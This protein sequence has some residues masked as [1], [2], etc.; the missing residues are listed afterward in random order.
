MTDRRLTNKEVVRRA[1]NAAIEWQLSILDSYHCGENPRPSEPEHDA[2]TQRFIDR[3]RHL[4][5]RI[6]EVKEQLTGSRM[7]LHEVMEA[8]L[9]AL[10]YMSIADLQK[11]PPTNK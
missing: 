5:R 8:E 4:L 9:E 1:M 2:E 10:P 3:E 7:T 6:R 11:L